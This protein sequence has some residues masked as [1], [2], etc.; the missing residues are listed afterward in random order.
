MTE[1][2]FTPEEWSLGQPEDNPPH[3]VRVVDCQDCT[4]A[5]FWHNGCD[6]VEWRDSD[7]QL[8]LA[9]RNLLAACQLAL[10]EIPI[11]ILVLPE[12]DMRRKAVL[13]EA[14]LAPG[15][16]G[17]YF[18]RFKEQGMPS[19]ESLE[20]ELLLDGKFN[21]NAVKSFVTDFR[22][23]LHFAGLIDANGVILSD[24][25]GD[26]FGIFGEVAVKENETPPTDQPLKTKERR[27]AA[28]SKEDVFT[29]EEGN[30][31]LQWPSSMSLESYQDVESWVQL[32]LRKV[33]RSIATSA[34]DGSGSQ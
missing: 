6:P 18:T 33:K 16:Y 10:R 20:H 22:K 26:A 29:L 7:V 5:T 27:M 31:V 1:P 23:T 32:V 21:H 25:I 9:S 4:I 2:Q 17:E 28:N 13:K 8:F 14:A 24:G 30:V 11:S 19:A 3:G 34:G 12:Q 15:I